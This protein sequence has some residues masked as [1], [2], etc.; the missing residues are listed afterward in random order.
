[1]TIGEQELL[2]VMKLAGELGVK[3]ELFKMMFM[4]N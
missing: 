1:M 4:D 2:V 3:I